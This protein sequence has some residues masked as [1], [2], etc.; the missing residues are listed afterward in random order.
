MLLKN[1]QNTHK[2]VSKPSDPSSHTPSMTWATPNFDYAS[3]KAVILKPVGEIK[4]I[5]LKSAVQ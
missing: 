4:V 5:L 2:V 1:T 3:E